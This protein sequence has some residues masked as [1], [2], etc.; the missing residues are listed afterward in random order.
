[1][2]LIDSHPL[3]YFSEYPDPRYDIVY[4]RNVVIMPTTRIK[5]YMIHPAPDSMIVPP[6]P[7]E[8]S[9]NALFISFISAIFCLP[10]AWVPCVASCS[11]KGFQV[12][13]LD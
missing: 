4:P 13:V 11:Y 10:I 6:R 1:M 8:M 7:S 9:T 2:T 3:P 12:A 5:G